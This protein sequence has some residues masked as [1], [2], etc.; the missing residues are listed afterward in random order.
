MK[1][2]VV[3]KVTEQEL[4]FVF[5]N[6]RSKIF[7]KML[8]L[9]LELHL[10]F[11]KELRAL[12]CIADIQECLYNKPPFVLIMSGFSLGGKHQIFT[13]QAM[14]RHHHLFGIEILQN[15]GNSFEREKKSISFL[16]TDILSSFL[17]AMTC[18]PK[19]MLNPWITAR[20]HFGNV[21]YFE[22]QWDSPGSLTKR[23][24]C[25][26]I[27]FTSMAI[28]CTH[29]KLWARLEYVNCFL[30]ISFSLGILKHL[31]LS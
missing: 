2:F 10:A 29:L 19:A 23:L 9:N 26:L 27:S 16:E 1:S 12:N 14:I 18:K 22:S 3:L 4:V 5:C 6:L 25:W 30:L 31:T 15:L 7:H 8:V 11:C 24:M 21:S 13:H 17:K 28:S 20:S